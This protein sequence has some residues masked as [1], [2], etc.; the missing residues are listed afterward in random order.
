MPGGRR[1]VAGRPARA[2]VGDVGQ[3]VDA[4]GGRRHRLGDRLRD[5]GRPDGEVGASLP[6]DGG[7]LVGVPAGEGRVAVRDDDRRYPRERD[8]GEREAAE[9]RRGQHAGFALDLA[10][11]VD[12]DLQRGLPGGDH[13]LV[14]D[15]EREPG[16]GHRRPGLAADGRGEDLERPGAG[17]GHV[18]VR[19]LLVADEGVHTRRHRVRQVGVEVERRHD[20]HRRS[21]HLA[22]RLDQEA[23]AVVVVRQRHRAVEDEQDAVDRQR[24]PDPGHDLVAQRVERLAGDPA[25][26]HDRAVGRRDQLHAE[27]PGLGDGA[28]VDGA[29]AF[30]V[31]QVLTADDGAEA[32]TQEIGERRR[33]PLEGV[34]LLGD[35]AGDDP[36]PGLHTRCRVTSWEWARGSLRFGPRETPSVGTPPRPPVRTAYVP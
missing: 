9:D 18:G 32:R 28:A 7:Q 27:P 26:R 1:A 17:L 8:V 33:L 3:D 34:G 5:R 31:E 12:R 15:D 35:A 25:A 21:D 36:H 11:P 30:E 22:D 24:G 29:G 6:A 10:G 16:V 13:R 20:R 23:F 14:G 19:V 2:R 4:A